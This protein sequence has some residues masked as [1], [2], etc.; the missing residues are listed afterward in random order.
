[1]GY[2]VFVENKLDFE[3]LSFVLSKA[4][5]VDKKRILIIDGPF[6]D[7]FDENGN[8]SIDYNEKP[9]DDRILCEAFNRTGDFLLKLEIDVLLDDAWPAEIDFA[10]CLS[11]EL[12]CN[13]LIG[14]EDPN[15]YHWILTSK[16]GKQKPIFV[17]VDRLDK[18]G[19]LVIDRDA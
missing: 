17:D 12:G 2:D 16:D 3:S 7:Y 4:L 6:F 9:N 18:Y 14:S 1:M 19:E 15:P 10:K 5:N 13:C 8:C 11:R